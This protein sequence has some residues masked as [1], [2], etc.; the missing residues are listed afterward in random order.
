MG[1]AGAA[2][3][4]CRVSEEALAYASVLN[5]R[6]SLPSGPCPV[7]SET[8]RCRVLGGS[9]E[10][11]SPNG[12]GWAGAGWRPGREAT[13]PPNPRGDPVCE[14]ARGGGTQWRQSGHGS[15]GWMVT[16]L[17]ALWKPSS[18]PKA[19]APCLGT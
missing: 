17:S 13:S 1:E 2:E 18:P 12:V 15:V 19:L 4:A 6:H 9:L 10:T 14:A 7:R 5:R 8:A 11:S 16:L 3:E